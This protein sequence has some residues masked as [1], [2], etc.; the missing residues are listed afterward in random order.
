MLKL[1]RIL[2]AALGAIASLCVAAQT[3]RQY[4]GDYY[5]YQ[6]SESYSA[7]D[8]GSV[9]LLRP[10]G[11]DYYDPSWLPL[12]LLIEGRLGVETLGVVR[13]LAERESSIRA[14]FLD[15]PGGLLRV[16][17]DLGKFLHERAWAI[18]VNV[19]AQCHSAC[20]L[21]FLGG[22]HRKMLARPEDF[23]FHRQYYLVDGQPAYGD[24]RLD[25]AQ[26]DQYLKATGTT[27]I[28]AEE[29]V[30]TSGEAS[31]THERLR[32]RGLTTMSVSEHY[33]LVL[34]TAVPR[35]PY[36][37]F[38]VGCHAIQPAACPDNPVLREPAL[39]TYAILA[40]EL[41]WFNDLSRIGRN[42]LTL[43]V[44][45]SGAN[46]TDIMEKDCKFAPDAFFDNLEIRLVEAA[47]SDLIA[48]KKAFEQ[49]RDA[50]REWCTKL[51]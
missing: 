36:E 14:V 16:G 30:G 7:Q 21:A 28:T 51:Q 42:L 12:A 40:K 26:I 1:V 2:F 25:I 29:I 27:G 47:A 23:S 3:G 13:R 33:R 24:W 11:F 22:G 5:L 20:A 43:A 41:G 31:F 4:S 45:Y 17:I 32:K 9:S 15:S 8:G 46:A 37:K 35:T 10:T 18:T 39:R 49:R 38:R 19:G 44:E 34:L 48:N 6:R 50:L